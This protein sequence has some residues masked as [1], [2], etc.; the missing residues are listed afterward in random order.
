MWKP[1]VPALQQRL[2]DKFVKSPF[3]VATQGA[4][5]NRIFPSVAACL[6]TEVPVLVPCFNNPTYL[7]NM[8]TQLRA[9]R[10]R[11]IIIVDNASTYPPMVECLSSLSREL[12]VVSLTEN[13]GARHISLD[14][15]T[16]ALLPQYFCVTDPDLEFNAQLPSDFLVELV[17]LTEKHAVGKAGFSL[18]ISDRSQLREDDFWIGGKE[19]KIWE[20]EEQFWQEPLERLNG[21]DQ[22]YRAPIDTTFAVY[23][24]KY[25]N[26][27][28]PYEAMRVA[29]KYTCR[30]LPWYKETLL[31]EDE[32][33][34]YRRTA[35]FAYY[36]KRGAEYALAL[37]LNVHRRR[38]DLQNA[39]PEVKD[40][41]YSRLIDW[42][43]GVNAR[44][45]E[46]AD[47]EI[48]RPYAKWY[49][50]IGN[51]ERID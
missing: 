13:K 14:E 34:F 39:F 49:S 11:N 28:N 7:R 33:T 32:E 10:L 27:E 47:Y 19:I 42:A 18:D 9:L 21:E 43:L 36:H 25:L 5:G 48:L 17:C 46:D 2:W 22:V 23:N 41:E 50:I 38:P 37:L 8:V 4:A 12:S 6:Q 20:W 40:G 3:L 51:K 30:H 44:R 16:Y 31:P 15:K 1:R 45:W 24:K 35:R 26:R 29:G